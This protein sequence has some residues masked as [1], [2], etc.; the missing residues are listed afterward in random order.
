MAAT[1]P[2]RSAVPWRDRAPERLVIDDHVA[3]RVLD[4]VVGAEAEVVVLELGRGVH[5]PALVAAER[6]FLVVAG[7]DVLPQLRPDLLDQVAPVADEREVPQDRM[8]ALSQVVRRN[9]RSCG[10][11]CRRPSH[12]SKY[13]PP[14]PVSARSRFAPSAV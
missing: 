3:G 12:G 5:P 4:I 13:A 1:P 10:E 7:D 6:P 14:M 8:P 9:R 11:R 2:G